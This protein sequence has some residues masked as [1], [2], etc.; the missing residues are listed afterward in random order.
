MTFFGGGM[1]ASE[2]QRALRS[3]PCSV[4]WM[5]GGV[6]AACMEWLCF[7]VCCMVNGETA[8]TGGF[9]WSCIITSPLPVRRGSGRV[10]GFR[11]RRNGQ[12]NVAAAAHRLLLRV[13]DG[14]RRRGGLAARHL[15]GRC[16][17][18]HH[19]PGRR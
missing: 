19:G 9:V 16:L 13:D 2:C 1:P 4:Q 15:D 14:L 8:C 3:A 10:V 5:V 11:R 7:G 18:V 17:L 12:W 6:T